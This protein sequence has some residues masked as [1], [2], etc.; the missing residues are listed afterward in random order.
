MG[1]VAVLAEQKSPVAWE[2]IGG[3]H[4]SLWAC[5][6]DG[7]VGARRVLFPDQFSARRA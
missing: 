1:R 6:I 3:R 2:S 5:D 7:S 4:D